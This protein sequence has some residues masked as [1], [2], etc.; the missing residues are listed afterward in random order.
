MTLD[1]FEAAT[2]GR[3]SRVREALAEEPE[4]A[5]AATDDGFTALHLA[6][7]FS[8]DV[9]SARAL[10][11]AGADPDALAANETGL[12]PINSAAAAS[13][14]RIVSLLLERGADVHAAQH[15]GY[16]PL[17]SAAAHGDGELVEVLLGAGADPTLRT[18][19]GSTPAELADE[20]GHPETARRLAELERQ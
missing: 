6:A 15:G 9:E 12:R 18:D 8:G 14:T 3:A 7:F 10:L 11:D 4:L 1:V 13:S 19:S 17:H 20:R 5:N 16:T 2:L